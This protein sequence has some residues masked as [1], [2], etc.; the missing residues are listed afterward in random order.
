MVLAGAARATGHTGAPAGP[1]PGVTK[2]MVRAGQNLWS[3][4]E[5][6]DPDAD[7]RRV[8]QEIQELNSM[9]TDQLQ[10]GQVLWVP[11]G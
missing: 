6:Y 5:A 3:L 4:A 1:G 7:T 9:T 11:R 8:I 2:V 10:P